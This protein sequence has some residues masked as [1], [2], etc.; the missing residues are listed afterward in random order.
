MLQAV[1]AL[2][3]FGDY[4]AR[5]VASGLAGWI[6][7]LLLAGSSLVYRVRA[8]AFELWLRFHWLLFVAMV[9]ALAVHRASD[10]LLGA[11]VWAAD[12]AFR[13][14]YLV[15]CRGRATA[16]LEP[17][18]GGLVKVT[19]APPPSSSAA[20]RFRPGQY[21][22]LCAPE[23]GLLDWHPLSVSSAPFEAAAAGGAFTLHVKV[24][25]DWSARLRALAETRAGAPVPVLWEGPYGRWVRQ[26]PAPPP[27][28][29]H[30]CRLRN[31]NKIAQRCEW[32]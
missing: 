5:T 8:Q 22:F 32:F 9:A 17:L 3:Y 31:A 16:T 29:A 27:S 1:Q 6:A 28:K 10:V 19:V 11:A 18:P 20:L 21:V 30:A 12:L 4:P 14:L 24:L 7:V 26:T 23:L 13:A 2:P 25:G 15:G